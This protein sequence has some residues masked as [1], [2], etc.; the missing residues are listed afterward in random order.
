MDQVR[1]APD[2]EKMFLSDIEC[3]SKP[4]KSH[5]AP[6]KDLNEAFITVSIPN[7]D[8][9]AFSKKLDEARKKELR[10]LIQRGSFKVILR[11]E[12]SPGTKAMR[13]RFVL[14]IKN[15]DTDEEVYK[16]R[17]VVQG[18]RDPMK[19][20]LVHNSSNLRQ[21]PARLLLS[22]ASILRFRVWTVDISQAY[23]QSASENMR[24]IFLEPPKEMELSSDELLKLMLPLYGL[25]DS[26]DRWHP[27]L[28]HRHFSDLRM[29]KLDTEP[30]FYFRS[31]ADILVGLSG[32]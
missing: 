12:L 23:L 13:G 27:T 26:G 29:E 22:M 4:F 15:K 24:D 7:N 30:S 19:Q 5:L 2:T 16:A 10:G 11:E 1:K 17:W 6:N 25:A 21:E 32:V 20:F 14:V 9:R 31:I 3:I 28:Y 18:F 8:P